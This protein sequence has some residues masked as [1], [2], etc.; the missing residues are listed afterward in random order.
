MRI[1]ICYFVN[2]RSLVWYKCRQTEIQRNCSKNIMS[3]FFKCKNYG[4]AYQQVFW[5]W[6]KAGLFSCLWIE[7][8]N[9]VPFF[10]SPQ[11][12]P[13][14]PSCLY[15]CTSKSHMRIPLS[16]FFAPFERKSLLLPI[17]TLCQRASLQPDTF[18]SCKSAQV[19]KLW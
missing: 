16:F 19:L 9:P 15:F 13:P 1:Y 3:D 8:M 6:L 11:S 2:H 18:S 4:M 12:Y 17:Y 10:Q 14:N 5:P 7:W